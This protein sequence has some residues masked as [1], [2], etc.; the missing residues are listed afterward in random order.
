M[1][2]TVKVAVMA[3]FA[4]VVGIN[5]YKSQTDMSLSNS[6][7]D[8]VEALASFDPITSDHTCVYGG[9]HCI[10]YLN[11]EVIFQSFLYKGVN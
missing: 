3:V 11:G 9:Q 10:L 6:Q 5:V 8:N 7:L 1:K 2:K 4:F